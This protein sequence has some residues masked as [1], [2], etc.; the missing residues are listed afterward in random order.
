MGIERR[1]L[2]VRSGAE[3]H[4]RNPDL[5]VACSNEFRFCR[6]H[7]CSHLLAGCLLRRRSLPSPASPSPFLS[8]PVSRQNG[9]ITQ[10]RVLSLTQEPAYSSLAAH[11]TAAPAWVQEEEADERR[12]EGGMKTEIPDSHPDSR[13]L[14]QHTPSILALFSSESCRSEITHSTPCHLVAEGGRIEG[15]RFTTSPA[16]A[17]LSPHEWNHIHSRHRVR[18]NASLSVD[19]CGKRHAES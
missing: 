14:D 13:Q 11:A 5:T 1:F 10:T 3:F 15:A 2:A 9:M 8:L 17:V 16:A 19:E 7:C 12:R 4:S 6:R 18:N